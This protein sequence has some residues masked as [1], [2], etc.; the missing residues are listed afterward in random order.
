MYS[1]RNRSSPPE[2]AR[3]SSPAA[4]APRRIPAAQPSQRSSSSPPS[5]AASPASSARRSASPSR[6]A[7]CQLAGLQ[8]Q[9]PAVRPQTRDRQPRGEAP[10]ERQRRPGGDM[11]CQ[12]RQ[13]FRRVAGAEEMGV[14]DHEHEV[15]ARAQPRGEPRELVCPLLPSANG[16]L[17]GLAL[18]PVERHGQLCEQARHIVVGLVD[19]QPGDGPA[20]A[21]GPLCG[22]RRLPVSGRGG[23]R[24]ERRGGR[25]QAI[26]ERRSRHRPG[27][28]RRY[29]NLCFDDVRRRG[30]RSA[31]ARAR[32]ARE[33]ARSAERV[34]ERAHH[35]CRRAGTSARR[36]GRGSPKVIIG[37]CG[38][39]GHPRRGQLSRARGDRPC[40]RVDRRSRPG[41]GVRRPRRRPRWRS[42]ETGRTSSSP[43][44]ACRRTTPTRAFGS[45]TS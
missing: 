9:Q 38:D 45:R 5:S 39:S 4:S 29:A 3:S 32:H 40:A 16:G 22:E 18:E 41:R 6:A 1:A 28:R 26:H 36:G 15:L 17:V 33:Y 30:S 35:S 25:S 20:F 43:T 10:D 19:R 12:C 14:V 7:Q 24:D 44:S 11:L 21:L 37:A 27:R 42:R 13:R 23:Q 34:P 2:T 8:L 31:G